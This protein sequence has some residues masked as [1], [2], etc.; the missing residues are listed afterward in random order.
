LLYFV[1]NFRLKKNNRRR[2]YMRQLGHSGVSIT[3][4]LLGTWAIGGVMWGGTNEKDSIEAIQASIDH[5]ITAIDTAAVYGFGFSE[6]VLGKALKGRRH[7]ATI[8]T[9]CGMRW[10]K[11]E[12]AR[13]GGAFDLQGNPLTIEKNSKPESI[14]FECEQSLKRLNTD[15]IDLYQI[16]WPDLNTAIEDSWEAMFQLKKQGKVRAI[17][18]SNYSLDELKRAHSL[19]PVDSIQLPYSLI[20]RDI[21]GEILPFC[22]KNAIAVLAYSPLE[23]GLLTGKV[24][25]IRTF[26]KGDHRSEHALFSAENRGLILSALEKIRPIADSHEA[27]LAQV[28]AAC[29]AEVPGITGVILGARNAAQALENAKALQLELS[30]EEKRSIMHLLEKIIPKL[31]Q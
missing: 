15:V 21:E 11:E 18:V 9:K 31:V 19:H 25:L 22:Q 10:S 5:G 24:S 2:K 7:L 27:T 4:L 8:A 29:S 1:E 17:G 28:I 3:P 20:R 23:R 26:P 14:I 13:P 30:A 12:R 16:H 6:E